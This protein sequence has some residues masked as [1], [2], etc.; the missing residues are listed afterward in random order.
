MRS[1]AK[2]AAGFLAGWSL[3][4]P[5]AAN[6][7]TAVL[8]AGGLELVSSADIVMESE[9]LFLSPAEVRIRY[10]FRN[11]SDRDIVARVA[12]PLPPV[13]FGPAAN[14]VLPFPQD[15]NFV[16]FS[17]VVDG[18]KLEPD[19]EQR[20]FTEGGGEVTAALAKA[21]L[22]LAAA[23]ADLFR[24]RLAALSS[25]VRER[26]VRQKILYQGG[27]TPDDIDGFEPQWELHAAYHWEQRFPAGEPVVVEHRYAPVVGS[28]YFV[29]EA[30]DL[31][32]AAA[33]F[34]EDYCLDKAGRAGIGHLLAAARKADAGGHEEVY[35]LADEV[36]YVL[37]TGANWK[38]PIGDFRLTIDKLRPDAI[39]SL[40]ESGLKKTGLKKTGLK[41]TGP[42]TFTVERAGFEPQQDIRFVVFRK[43]AQGR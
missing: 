2:L 41:K 14:F 19:L 37:R 6:D 42:T 40:C 9:A 27:E 13:P 29:G 38:G 35:V 8:G 32:R 15:E 26:L 1:S 31:D 33:E 36:D 25:D 7:S 24:E 12:F 11:E 20:A 30:G 3:G 23:N 16:G 28:S 21:G 18:R 22:P 10:V 34:G 17:V 5:V 4:A 43:A 39:L